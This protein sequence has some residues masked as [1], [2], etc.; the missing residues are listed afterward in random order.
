MNTQDEKEC[1]FIIN[2]SERPYHLRADSSAACKDWV[3]TLNRVKEARMHVGN[4]KLAM[5]QDM[6][7]PPDLLDT[8]TPRVL[9]FDTNRPR[10]HVVEDEDFSAWEAL[11]GM[12]ENRNPN[13]Y[14]VAPPTSARLARW[15]KPKTSIARIASKVLAWARSI[16]KYRCQDADEHVV[17]DH[18]LHPPGHDDKFKR[19]GA[20]TN[21]G[22]YANPAPTTGGHGQPH[23][24]ASV[25]TDHSPTWIQNQNST[26]KSFPREVTTTDL[27]DTES[28]SQPQSP[29]ND[30][31]EEDDDD[32]EARFLS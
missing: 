3:I 18:H 11:G 32:D 13:K 5:P 8:F 1:C 4:V 28:N 10:T 15:Q 27:L 29:T 14:T 23:S 26:D 25:G 20:G 7:Q 6:N 21:L 2:I 31:V 12:E 16:R 19:S 17:L 22:G 30:N 24:A 9:V